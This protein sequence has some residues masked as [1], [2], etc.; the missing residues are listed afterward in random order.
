MISTFL[1]LVLWAEE[2]K[3]DSTAEAELTPE[4]DDLVE[5]VKKKATSP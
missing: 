3:G 4:M 1:D 5:S 2:H